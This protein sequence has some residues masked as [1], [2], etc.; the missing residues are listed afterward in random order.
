M[1]MLEF[2]QWD[3]YQ[4]FAVSVMR[5]SR[6]IM[7][8]ENQRFLD[9]VI[10]TSAKRAQVI[11][12]G[13]VLWRAQHDHDWRKEIMRDENG[14]EADSIDV[15]YPCTP[16]RMRPLAYCAYEGRVNPK[17]IPCLYL[18]NDRDTAMTETRPWMA[19]CVSVGQ[20]V[21]L[22]DL[23]V[24]DC[25]RDKKA[26]F[27]LSLHDK[28]PDPA[29]REE[30][31]W[32]AINRAFSTP[33]TRSDD[34]AEYAPTQVLAEAFRSHGFEGIIYD[35]RLGIG[36]TVAL[37][38]LEMAELANCELFRVEEVKLK[39][40]ST[41]EAYYVQKYYEDGQ[42]KHATVPAAESASLT[43]SE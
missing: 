12:K 24:V 30:Y 36:K 8:T 5:K 23:K 1:A 2:D 7:D 22:K 14:N 32:G 34:S 16:E 31:V 10:D 18:S 20:F 17:G 35:S 37:F 4:R 38:D 40:S 33:V 41:G 3:Q 6:H 21:T 13:H 9:T 43:D 15:E 26:G 19:S 42:A 27:W 28:Q 39:F 11:G 29:Q 25:S